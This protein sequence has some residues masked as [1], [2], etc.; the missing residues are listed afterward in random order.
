MRHIKALLRSS[1]IS[2]VSH[3]CC[4]RAVV[5][6]SA[7][8]PLFLSSSAAMMSGPGA[9]LLDSECMTFLISSAVGA[10]PQVRYCSRFGESCC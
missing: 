1:G 6:S 2:L 3:M 4:T 8:L 10:S 9:F 7:A 5:I